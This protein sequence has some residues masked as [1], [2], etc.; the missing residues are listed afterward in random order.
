MPQSPKP[1]PKKKPENR[2][3]PRAQASVTGLST[4]EEILAAARAL[5]K[6][7]G[8]NATTTRQIADKAGIRQPSLFHYFKNKDAIFRAVAFGT[9]VPVLDYV[10]L[11]NQ[12]DLTIRER[13]Y[14]LVYFDT[15]HLCTNENLMGSPLVFME[16][17]RDKFPEFWQLRED[18]IDTYR[19]AL[20]SGKRAGDFQFDDLEVTTQL[21][22]GLGEST[23]NWY[24]RTRIKPRVVAHGAA[25]MA[26]KSVAIDGD[27]AQLAQYKKWMA[28]Q[29]L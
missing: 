26:L 14:R 29:A 13:L 24:K 16:V 19:K 17:G 25:S 27:V 3:R 11:L 6:E 18:I 7:Q 1:A 28:K 12:E 10:A 20:R 4:E 15:Y 2:G 21:I 8:F 9:V 5:F 23:L 22:F